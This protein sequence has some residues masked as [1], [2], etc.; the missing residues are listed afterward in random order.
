L[1]G[2]AKN[3][4]F[5]ERVDGVDGGSG[6]GGDYFLP[7]VRK[8][9]KA[10]RLRV[11]VK[12]DDEDLLRGGGKDLSAHPGG[13]VVP[14]LSPG[15]EGVIAGIV[16]V[17][18]RRRRGEEDVRNGAGVDLELNLDRG[19]SVPPG[20]QAKVGQG[21]I[22]PDA[23]DTPETALPSAR[24]LGNDRAKMLP[25]INPQL[26]ND[27]EANAGSNLVP[28]Y[29]AA[30]LFSWRLI[31]GRFS[32]PSKEAKLINLLVTPK[33]ASWSHQKVALENLTLALM[34]A[35]RRVL[36]CSHDYKGSAGID[37]STK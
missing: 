17:A 22:V 37:S 12:R 32:D 14:Q 27:D 13:V 28:F 21:T 33:F 18:L 19:K 26:N 30:V 34:Q 10:L 2:Y 1:R 35:P 20:W 6:D 24:E 25:S 16:V 5:T 3:P 8:V 29:G 4:K 7:V 31:D 36:G 9:A 23:D 11:L 15:R